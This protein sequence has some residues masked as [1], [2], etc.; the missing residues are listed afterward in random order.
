MDHT[1]EVIHNLD[2]MIGFLEK[3]ESAFRGY[4]ITNDKEPLLKYESGK[5][6]IES[7]Y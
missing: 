4:L 3:S 2:N 5:K 7:E 6:M 1:N